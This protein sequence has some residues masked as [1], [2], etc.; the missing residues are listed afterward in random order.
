MVVMSGDELREIRF[1]L[2]LTQMQM[3]ERLGC[4]GKWADR[5]VRRWESYQR[6]PGS[7]AV[8]ARTFAAVKDGCERGEE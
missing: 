8:L 1:E 2:G 3:A 7:V 5:T 4:K 6:V